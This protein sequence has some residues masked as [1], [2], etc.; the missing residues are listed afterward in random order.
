MAELAPNHVGGRRWVLNRPPWHP[1]GRSPSLLATSRR[2]PPIRPRIA[3]HAV[4]RV[5]GEPDL[6]PF[7]TL[8]AGDVTVIGRDRLDVL[9]ER[10]EM[11]L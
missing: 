8:E 10:Q 11:S 7:G 2:R 6:S 5:W 1:A 9:R 4:N 3:H